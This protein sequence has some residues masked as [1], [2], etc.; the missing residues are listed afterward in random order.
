MSRKV[1][2]IKDWVS[3][4]T[5]EYPA[6]IFPTIIGVYSSLSLAK[7]QILKYTKVEEKMNL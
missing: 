3:V 6:N 2:I 4:I 7:E 5:D 1:F